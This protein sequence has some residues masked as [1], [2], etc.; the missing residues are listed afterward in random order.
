MKL[1][2]LA[3]LLIMTTMLFGA[4]DGAPGA[5][6]ALTPIEDSPPPTRADMELPR[7]ATATVPAPTAIPPT[8]VP[9]SPEPT[10]SAPFL[11]LYDLFMMS[12]SRGYAIVTYGE[13]TNRVM[14][15]MDGGETWIDITPDGAPATTAELHFLDENRGWV[16]YRSTSD[17]LPTNAYTIW[18]T[19]DGG[20]SWQ[21][22]A[23][24]DMADIAM[25]GINPTGF[26]FL[27]TQTGWFRVSLG[28]GMNKSYPAI[29]R[30]SNGGQ[31]WTRM[32]DPY[33]DFELLSFEKTGM[34]FSD[35]SYGWVTRD[36]RG[37]EW[38]VYVQVTE[39]GGATWRSIALPEPT[40]APGLYE[41]G[42]WCGA[43]YPELTARGRGSLVSTCQQQENDETVYRTYLYTTTDGGTSWTYQNMPPGELFRFPGTLVVA[44]RTIYRSTDGGENWNRMSTVDFYPGEYSFVDPMNGWVMATWE[45]GEQALM[46]TND[47][48]ATWAPT[49]FAL[50]MSRPTGAE[51]TDVDITYVSM[52]D[53]ARGWAIGAQPGGND[54]VLI[55]GDGGTR[56]IDVSPPERLLA[57]GSGVRALG[58]FLDADHA[59]VT[60]S[61]SGSTPSD[62]VVWHTSD[63][64]SS[65]TSG[66]LTDIASLISSYSP[67]HMFFLDENHGWYM[68]AVDAGMQKVYS[69]I[70]A[71]R[72]GGRTWT[73]I[74]DPYTDTEVQS[75]DKTGMVFADTIHGWIT[76]DGRGVEV[77]LYVL[78][79]NDGGTTWTSSALPEP[80]GESGLFNG[81]RCGTYWPVMTS[82]TSGFV[83]GRCTNY[84]G[85]SETAVEYL[86]TTTNGGASWSYAAYPGGQLLAPRPT[87]LYALGEEMY[88]SGDG[89]ESWDLIK[90]VSWEGQFSFVDAEHG[91]A[92][93]RA[94][95]EIALVRTDD[96]GET[97]DMLEY[98]VFLG[99]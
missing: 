86:Y 57:G 98:Q 62:V 80:A 19:T 16:A 51:V 79:T 22:S 97:W 17:G 3:I 47:G 60:F 74:L 14:R 94:G 92:V 68:A 30:T 54:R 95:E 76:Y 23:P 12:I 37:V 65:W 34:V 13:A 88:F 9:P 48:G 26:F 41:G 89:G 31:T 73:R 4:C 33:T 21:T 96:G 44:G 7:P 56:W 43:Y 69:V 75:F 99:E 38:G 1:R 45:N 59:W 52:T 93:A 39:D 10:S 36:S 64:G 58:Y 81:S 20:D 77:G 18:R 8:D 70:Y 27:N 63:G 46:R 29:Y 84:S 61:G 85:N 78:I 24:I 49:A 90:M 28:G 42:G 82:P 35:S 40:D 87:L 53:A 72:D 25:E 91:W 71:T 83:I 66:E 67:Y 50:S 32:M 2:M 5:E 55:T 6:T 11:R 15:T